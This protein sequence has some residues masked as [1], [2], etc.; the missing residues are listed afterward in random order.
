VTVGDRRRTEDRVYRFRATYASCALIGNVE[1]FFL[2]ESNGN[3]IKVIVPD[4]V[5]LDAWPPAAA[6]GK[7]VSR[8]G[9]PAPTGAASI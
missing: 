6:R 5:D 3:A 9:V 1:V 7:A 4:C 2:R 8:R